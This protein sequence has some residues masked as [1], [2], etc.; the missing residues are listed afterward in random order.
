MAP[1]VDCSYCGGSTFGIFPVNEPFVTSTNDL[2]S[3]IASLGALLIVASLAIDPLSQQLVHYEFRR[4]TGPLGS[5]SLP[6]A[7]NWS[8]VNSNQDTNVYYGEDFCCIM[9]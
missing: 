1:G 6:I 3:Q 9:F 4:A 7:T 2:S 8:D 5:A